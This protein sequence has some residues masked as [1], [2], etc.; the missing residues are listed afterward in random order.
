VGLGDAGAQ[1]AQVYRNIGRILESVGATPRDVVKINTILTAR[2]NSKAITEERLKFFGDH[3][4]PHTGIVIT[5]LGSPE[6]LVEVEVIAYL[7]AGRRK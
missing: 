7:P 6:V 4:P 1:A 2:E 5:G 3:K